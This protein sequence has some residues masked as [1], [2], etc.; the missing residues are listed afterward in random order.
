ML[1]DDQANKIPP[2][3]R[4]LVF[5][6]LGAAGGAVCGGL[7]GYVS[8]SSTGAMFGAYVGFIVGGI[9]STIAFLVLRQGSD[10]H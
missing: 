7:V 1:V 10:D 8:F 3:N 2:D 5:A 4:P 9:V 6:V